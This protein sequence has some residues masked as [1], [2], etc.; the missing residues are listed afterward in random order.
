M[1]LCDPVHDLQVVVKYSGPLELL[2]WH[3]LH[4]YAQ[5]ERQPR[6]TPQRRHSNYIPHSAYTDRLSA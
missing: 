3:Y 5:P 4:M 6:D 2:G 1:R